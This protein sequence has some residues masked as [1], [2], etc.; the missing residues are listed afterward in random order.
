MTRGVLCVGR[1]RVERARGLW[2]LGRG[3]RAGTSCAPPARR[4]S[5]TSLA[6][7]SLLGAVLDVRSSDDLGATRAMQ[8][9]GRARA[10]TRRGPSAVT[11]VPADERARRAKA[12]KSSQRLAQDRGAKEAQMEGEEQGSPRR[13]ACHCARTTTSSHRACARARLPAPIPS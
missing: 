11:H 1:E 8:M 12:R 4:R 6:N 2:P 13:T 7:L 3:L 9:V 10:G 5:A